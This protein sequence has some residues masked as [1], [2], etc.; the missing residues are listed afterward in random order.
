ML[1]FVHSL[2]NPL[3]SH[4]VATILCFG[5]LGA[6][7]TAFVATLGPK[8]GLRTM[9]ITRFNSGCIGCTLYSILNIL[10]Q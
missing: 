3:S 5:F 2:F 9:M 10:S 6:V 1:S 7:S 4:V 8:T